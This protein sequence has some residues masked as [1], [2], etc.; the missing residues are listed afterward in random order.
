MTRKFIFFINPISGT[1]NKAALKPLIE[2]RMGKEGFAFQFL[3]TRKDGDYHFLPA[4]IK[5]QNITDIIVCGGD[6]T[7]NQVAA[8][9][10]H[11]DVNVGIIP[12][13]SGNGLAF[14]A[15]IPKNAAKALNIIMNGKATSIDS[16]YINN[17]FSCM[18]CG[19]GF[20]AQVA[21]DFAMQKKRG[22][23][24]YVKQTIRNF[25]SAAPYPF[26]LD[27]NNSHINTKAFFIS[28]ANSNQFGN[29]VTIAP[30]ASL[31]DGML[32]IVI[33]NKMS[34][35]RMIYAL[36]KHVRFGILQ[37]ALEKGFQNRSIQYLQTKK[38]VIQNPG[39]APL[40]IDGEPSKTSM[41]FEINIIEKAFRLLQ[42]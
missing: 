30:K 4:V 18:L 1:K 13:G 11:V 14:S 37:D 25:F 29:N 40:H 41:V 15:G 2:K 42:S 27:V 8:S 22:L 28:I 16:F 19:L 32:D 9:L 34:K 24:T 35:I 7:V 10:I 3:D 12:M 20:D 6:G 21:H 33:V 5:E 39:R 23:A 31:H 26:I 36:L 17:Q 38:L